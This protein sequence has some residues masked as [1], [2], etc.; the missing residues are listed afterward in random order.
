MIISI[1]KLSTGEVI[2]AIVATG[3]ATTK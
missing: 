3:L 2:S 1:K